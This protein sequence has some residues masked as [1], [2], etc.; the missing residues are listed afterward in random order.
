MFPTNEFFF[1]L[2]ISLVALKFHRNNDNTKLSQTNE[3]CTK[4]I[5][6]MVYNRTQFTIINYTA[7]NFIFFF[8]SNIQFY[9]SKIYKCFHMLK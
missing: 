5:F 2:D 1:Q 3:S 6:Y 8:E 7:Y 9:R 4:N